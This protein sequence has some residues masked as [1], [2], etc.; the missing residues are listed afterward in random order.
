MLTVAVAGLFWI[1]Q[2][3][4]PPAEAVPNVA[5]PRPGFLAPDFTLET[6]DGGRITLSQLRGKVVMVN[7]WAS[8]CPPCRKEMPAIEKVYRQNRER[9]LE[10]LAVN[11][12]YQDSL[13][14]VTQFVQE[15]DLSFPILLDRDG[16]VGR[17]YLLRAL[18]TTFFIDRQGYIRSV[19]P[20]GPMSESLIQSKIEDLLMERP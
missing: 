13:K 7:L 1:W 11:T 17:R 5:S 20:G 15:Y 6:L 3:A 14:G 4:A 9:G 2:S 19:V 8:W 16:S 18:P 12:T 10:V